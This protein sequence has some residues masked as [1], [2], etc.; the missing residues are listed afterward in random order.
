MRLRA[1]AMLQQNNNNNYPCLRLSASSQEVLQKCTRAS[2]PFPSRLELGLTDLPVI[3]GLRAWVLCSKNGRKAGGL[4]GGGQTPAALLAGRGS[5]KFCPRPAD[6]YLS[7]EWSHVGYGLPL[8]VDT[9]QAGVGGLVTVATLKTSEGSGK[10]QTQC[11]FVRTQK[12]NCL[13]SKVKAGCGTPGSAGVEGWLREKTGGGGGGRHSGAALP[14]Q[15]RVNRV[16]AQSGRRWR[17]SGNAAGLSKERQQREV[18]SGANAVGEKQEEEDKECCAAT[19]H[20]NSEQDSKR[21]GDEKDSSPGCCHDTPAKSCCLCGRR[22]Q[23]QEDQEGLRRGASVPDRRDGEVEEEEKTAGDEEKKGLSG[24]SDTTNYDREVNSLHPEPQTPLKTQISLRPDTIA[25]K[26]ITKSE[27]EVTKRQTSVEFSHDPSEP[28]G[29]TDDVTST[30]N[31]ASY[32]RKTHTENTKAVGQPCKEVA[33]DVNRLFDPVDPVQE[34]EQEQQSFQVEEEVLRDPPQVPVLSSCCENVFMADLTVSISSTASHPRTTE[35]SAPVGGSTYTTGPETEGNKEDLDVDGHL[36]CDNTG[37]ETVNKSEYVGQVHG[38]MT[39]STFET[40]VPGVHDD[41]HAVIPQTVVSEENAEQVNT[42]CA[43]TEDSRL[44]RSAAGFRGRLEEDRTH[45]TEAPHVVDTSGPISTVPQTA[46]ITNVLH[47]DPSVPP[48]F[49][50]VNPSPS[51]SLLRSVATGVSCVEVERCRGIA[52]EEQEAK[53]EKPW[54]QRELEE[55]V[56]TTRSSTVS[57]DGTR[58]DEEF[59]LF[60]QAEGEPSWSQGVV[61]SASMP[62][63]SREDAGWTNGSSRQSEDTWTAFP[64]QLVEEGGDPAGQ[65]WPNGAAEEKTANQNLSAVFMVAFP[66]L[67][68]LS[69]SDPCHQDPVPTLSQLL[70]INQQ[71]NGGGQDWGLLDTFHDLNKMI[72][73]RY[74]RANDVSR[75]LLLKTLHLQKTCTVSQHT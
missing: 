11:L 63:G 67:P 2:L 39:S 32:D 45:V 58:K 65:W 35:L 47:A 7:E 12:G 19:R 69:S 57:T 38:H 17:R 16:R 56:E 54:L 27:M 14:G 53:K 20:N 21:S 59:G 6:A 75:D 34:S 73:R 24:G 46:A 62:P 64:Q 15:T 50:P 10:T 18:H 25:E 9:R 51:P 36:C 44:H 1:G 52:R 42:H 30:Q 31:E 49:H 33:T 48:S 41:G 66:S 70:S 23:Q 4:F 37:F 55:Q 13:Y 74:R 29:V 28:D 43:L 5:S 61:A 68:G 22:P 40:V 72:G 60:V 71:H 26:D 8:G 3:R